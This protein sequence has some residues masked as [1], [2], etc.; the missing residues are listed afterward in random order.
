IGAASVAVGIG[1]AA[2]AF[3]T[4]Q[5]LGS[6][7]GADKKECPPSEQGTISRLKAHSLTA[8]LTLG[9]GAA[10]LAAG[11]LLL[12]TEPH[13]KPEPPRIHVSASAW[14]PALGRSTVF[15]SGLG[16]MITGTY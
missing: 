7:C 15:A 16:F 11:A 1:F 4:S 3:A 6:V 5:H 12:L 14:T 9:G 13:P 2:S 10:L 8:D